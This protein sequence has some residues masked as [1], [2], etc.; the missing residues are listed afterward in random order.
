MVVNND[1][2]SSL[3]LSNLRILDIVSP[4]ITTL[5]LQFISSESTLHSLFVALSP[6]EATR[7]P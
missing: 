5:T 3:L 1:S 7:V 6:E 4:E 2:T